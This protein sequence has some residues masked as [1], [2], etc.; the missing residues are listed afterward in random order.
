MIFKSPAMRLT[1][2]LILLM[3]NFLFLA[4]MIGF[5]PDKSESVMELRKGMSESLALM[6]CAAAEKEEFQIIQTILRATVERNE[7]IQS[8][9][10]RTKNG[11]L[12]ALAGEHLAYWKPTQDGKSTPTHIS[13]PL[14]LKDKD[15]A[16]MEI[17]FK[18]LWADS[19]TSGFTNSFAGLMGFMVLS[20]L[21]SYFLLMKK[22]LRELDPA[23]VIPARVQKAFD[24]LQEGV[25]ILDEKEQIVMANQFFAKILGKSPGEMIGLKGSELG[26][27]DCQ[28]QAQVKELPWFKVMQGDDSL[29]T[30]SMKLRNSSGNEI[31]L[32]VNAS[33]LNSKAGKNQGALV[34][35]DDITQLEEKNFQLNA[36]VDQLQEA[37]EDINEKSKK[38]KVLASCDPMTLCLNR[39]SFGQKL[40]VLFARAKTSGADLCCMMADIDFFKKVNDNYGHATGDEVIK[41]VAHALKTNTRDTDLV[42]R[43]GGEEF[44]L[45][46]PGL[47]MDKAVQIAE[48]IRMTIE[49]KSYDGVKVTVSQGVSSI[50]LNA[51]KPEEL[52]DQADKALYAA[53]ESG[54]N[55]VITWGQDM[56][57]VV[58]AYNDAGGEE[59]TREAVSQS[60]KSKAT[61]APKNQGQLQQRVLELEGLL[62]KRTLELNHYK[63]Y[64]FKTG[65]PNRSLFEDRISREITRSKRLKTLVT[66]LSINIDTI[67]RVSET[68]GHKVAEQL[69]KACG[70]RLN[71]VLRVNIDTVAVIKEVKETSSISL[72]SQAEFG[73]LLTDI[74][75]VDNVTWV[76]KRMLD[77]FKKPFLINGNEIYATAYFGVSLFPNDG[78]TAEEL[79]SSAVNACRYAKK[80]GGRN[81]YLFASQSLNK[82][83]AGKLKIE[84]CLHEAI[85]NNEFQLH[86]QPKID[87]ATGQ[88][89]GFEALLR[90]H[91]NHLGFVPPDK[92]IP[93]AEQSRQINKI[94]DWVLYTACQQLRTWMDMG[95]DIMPVAINVSGIQLSQHNFPHRIQAILDKFDI[96]AHMLE[97][98]LTETALVNSVDESFAMLEQ[99]RQMGIR[100][101]MDDFGTGYSSFSYLKDIPLSCLKIDKSFIF[102]VNINDNVDKLV[103]SMV[104]IAH[105]LGIEVVAEGVEEKHQADYLIELG[106]EY[107]QGYYFSRPIPQ[108]EVV[109]IVEKKQVEVLN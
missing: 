69:V 79:H 70:E 78:Q 82:K 18:P 34:T 54:R 3:A 53:K 32:A 35:F 49:K 71:N 12:V 26:W 97:I 88:I 4:N 7:D 51:G 42:S 109:D 8:A 2:S 31:K 87:S 23:A 102:D 28:T 86:Y 90:W 40:D 91:N 41:G 52:I 46:L 62:K 9:A 85:Q 105:G 81:R 43:Y 22:A 29:E 95:L 16:T 6:F 80:S 63:M 60:E 1:I 76:M 107:L 98:E 50:K 20:C 100:I 5:I 89:A 25:L 17:C 104:S 37:N 55:R 75:K 38:L 24:V 36:M 19:L 21:V 13:V 56:N 58:E 92:F 101:S 84:S 33:I 48:R 99:I 74:K 94:G 93:V 96:G 64:D 57:A 73:I 65:L 72:I 66:V 47:A 77:S 67:N 11:R 61:V 39:R 106:C 30:A 59:E 83:A 103:S 68:L 44:C 45:I 10:I 14:F 27:L 108:N 15:W